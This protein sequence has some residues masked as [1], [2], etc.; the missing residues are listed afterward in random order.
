M[1]IVISGQDRVG[2][3]A[4]RWLEDLVRSL[5]SSPYSS[6]PSLSVGA[7]IG[8]AGL[9]GDTYGLAQAT[10]QSVYSRTRS[11]RGPVGRMVFAQAA[12]PHHPPS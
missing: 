8:G 4:R 11:R 9:D 3:K 12:A 1:C 2:E 5:L 7:S 6:Q 10:R